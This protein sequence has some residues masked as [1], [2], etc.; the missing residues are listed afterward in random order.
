MTSP[1]ESERRLREAL[2]ELGYTR[3]EIRRFAEAGVVGLGA[4]Q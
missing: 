2:A 3:A 4:P 1:T